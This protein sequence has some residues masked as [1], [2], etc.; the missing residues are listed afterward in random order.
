MRYPVD[1]LRTLV[2]TYGIKQGA[3]G[4]SLGEHI[5]NLMRTDGELK[6]TCWEQRKN[7][8]KNQGTLS[9]C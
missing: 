8:K 9:A 1:I 4:N 2:K 5:G 3:I 6:G 7:G